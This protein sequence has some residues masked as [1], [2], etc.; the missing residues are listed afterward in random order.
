MDYE[1]KA[2]VKEILEWVYCIVIAVVLALLVRYF[3]GTPTIVQ[4]PSM[5]PTLKQ[6]HRLILNRT[7][8]TFNGV[9]DRGDIITFEA[10][11]KVYVSSAEADLQN[12]VAEYEHNINGIFSKFRYY[13]LELGKDSYIKRVIGLPGEHVKIENGKVYINDVELDEPYLREGV[14]TGQLKGA[15]TPYLDVVVPKGHLFLMGDNRPNSTDSRCFG[16][17]PYDKIESRVV[18]RFWPLAKFGTVE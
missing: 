10:P 15:D 17:V 14:L 7:I 2:K 18:I 9:P 4:Q 5:F 1:G 6:G 3:I 8:R 13:V 16:C 11:S 12:P